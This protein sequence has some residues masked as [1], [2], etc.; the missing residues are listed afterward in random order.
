MKKKRLLST[1]AL[2][3]LI[4]VSSIALSAC[5]SKAQP[6]IAWA[7]KEILTYEVFDGEVSVGSMV[8][9]TERSNVGETFS[10]DL[11]G[12]TY[13]EADS[14]T[15]ITVDTNK[16]NVVSTALWN[17]Y[18]VIAQS[19]V[20]TDKKDAANNYS[21][22]SHQNKKNYVYSINGG[23]S[24]KVKIGSTNYCYSD[25]IYQYIRCY[26]AGSQPTSIKI[27]DPFSDS[28][29]TL[30]VNTGASAT[31][32]TSYTSTENVD[33]ACQTMYFSLSDTPTGNAITVFYATDTDANNQPVPMGGISKRVPV[34][35]IE[36]NMSYIL[37]NFAVAIK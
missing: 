10:K 2:V 15:T 9:V 35:I 32:N 29:V 17:G 24:K 25:F 34:K 12:S 28:A 13:G 37:T 8:V 21:L 11:N 7:Y 36:N 5:N 22:T 26:A 30:A 33:V 4:A 20:Y 6:G 3:I 18:Y 23:T 31:V 1:V 14:R 19:K 27:A 16:V